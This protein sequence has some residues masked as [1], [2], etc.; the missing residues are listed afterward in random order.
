MTTYLGGLAAN[1]LSLAVLMAFAWV[2]REC[3]GNSGRVDTIW[4]F[5]VGLVGAG[6]ALWPPA[7]G[8]RSKDD[9]TA[10]RRARR[11]R[12]RHYEVPQNLFAQVLGPDRKYSSCLYKA[13]ATKLQHRGTIE[14][15]LCNLCRDETTLCVTPTEPSG[16]SATIG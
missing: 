1:A 11:R 8:T 7:E 16:A 4:P 5:A 12:T 13:D 2:V 15:S 3:T 10:D 14:A 9:A 6:S